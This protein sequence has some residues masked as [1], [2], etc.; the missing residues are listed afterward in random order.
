MTESTT[1]N[2]EPRLALHLSPVALIRTALAK[3]RVLS[4]RLIGPPGAGKTQL[5]QETLKQLPHPKRVAVIAVN[6][7]AGRDAD[8]LHGAAGLVAHIDAPVPTAAAIW[9]VLS[10]I[11]LSQFDTLLIECAGGLMDLPDL[12]QDASVAVFSV[13]GGD[14]KAMEYAGLLE[15]VSAVVLTKIDLRPLVKFDSRIF[16]SDVERINPGAALH[17]VSSL[18]GSGMFSWLNWLNERRTAKHSRD[19]KSLQDFCENFVG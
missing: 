13:S 1:H 9:R 3:Q 16:R 7:A 2:A 14:D 11:D 19:E 10:K 6:P 12:G 5:I 17:E 8:R 18:T 15:R 4:L